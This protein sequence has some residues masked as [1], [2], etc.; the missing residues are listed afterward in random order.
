MQN[1]YNKLN[2]FEKARP[3]LEDLFYLISE[4]TIK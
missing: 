2:N 4:L 3:K 1:N